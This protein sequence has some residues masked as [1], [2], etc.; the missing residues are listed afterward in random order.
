M[1]PTMVLM[2]NQ[3]LSDMMAYILVSDVSEEFAASTFGV[4]AS[5]ALLRQLRI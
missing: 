4:Y 3:V 2:K 1:L 5:H